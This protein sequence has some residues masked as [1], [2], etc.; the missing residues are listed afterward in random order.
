MDK[1]ELQKRL[2]KLPRYQY[3][4]MSGGSLVM[5]GLREQTHDVN[6]CVSDGLAV[7]LG[8]HNRTPNEHGVYEL[9]GGLDVMIGM[10][11]VDYNLVDGYLCETLASILEFKKERNLPKDQKDIEAI[12][13]YFVHQG[14]S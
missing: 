6:I 13:E 1:R 4:L 10:N 5:R 2:E 8:I 12:E 11:R 14:R 3:I 9:P 7:E